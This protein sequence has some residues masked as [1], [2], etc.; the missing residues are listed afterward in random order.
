MLD[1]FE[2]VEQLRDL[3]D[4]CLAQ[5]ARALGHG[6]AIERIEIE[7]QIANVSRGVLVQALERLLGLDRIA[8]EELLCVERGV[9]TF[10]SARMVV[11]ALDVR[12][13]TLHLESSRRRAELVATANVRRGV[14][15][16]LRRGFR[17]CHRIAAS[18]VTLRGRGGSISRRRVGSGVSGFSG[19]S[20]IS[21]L[22]RGRVGL[23]L[24]DFLGG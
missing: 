5:L 16:V 17:G 19:F 21:G 2:R 13:H 14:A 15:L 3:H 12:C 4:L 22:R 11:P 23:R 9:E 10:E 6:Q 1:G 24:H 20:G 7:H 8:L 18:C